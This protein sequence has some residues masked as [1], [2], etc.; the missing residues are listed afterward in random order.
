MRQTMLNIEFHRT[1]Q[2]RA[3]SDVARWTFLDCLT[4]LWTCRGH[5]CAVRGSGRRVWFGPFRIRC[6][7]CSLDVLEKRLRFRTLES[8]RKNCF[9]PSS[10]CSSS[11]VLVKSFGVLWAGPCGFPAAKV[12]VALLNAGFLEVHATRKPILIYFDILSCCSG[13][14]LEMCYSAAAPQNFQGKSHWYGYG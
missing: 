10:E 5:G 12:H 4:V 8:I 13:F 9:S 3:D 7:L 14:V 6:A 1:C 11:M 2:D